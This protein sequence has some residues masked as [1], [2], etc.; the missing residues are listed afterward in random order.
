MPGASCI[1][2]IDDR[3]AAAEIEPLGTNAA[4][5]RL[6]LGAA[7]CLEAARRAALAGAE[8]TMIHPRGDPAYPAPR[9]LYAACGFGTVDHTRSYRRVVWAR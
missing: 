4:H 2:W 8:V 9:A 5:R 1:A 6:G 3:T 7:V